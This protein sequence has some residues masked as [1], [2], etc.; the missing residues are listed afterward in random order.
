MSELLNIFS[1]SSINTIRS[2]FEKI[3]VLYVRPRWVWKS[4]LTKNANPLNDF[5]FYLLFYGLI[6]YIFTPNVILVVKLVGLQLI[7]KLQPLL[8]FLIP[9][10]FFNFIWKQKINLQQIFILLFIF[11][12]QIMPFIFIPIAIADFCEIESPYI[13]AHNAFSILDIM[14]IVIV[15]LTLNIS[16][17]KKIIWIFTN[18]LFINIFFLINPL[19]H[20]FYPDLGIMRAKLEMNAPQKEFLSYEYVYKDSDKYLVANYLTVLLKKDSTVINVS[21]QY[22]TV[23]LV[24]KMLEHKVKVK[25]R[26]QFKLDDLIYRGDSSK[27]V[28]KDIKYKK[29]KSVNANLWIKL[30]PDEFIKVKTLDSLRN[31]YND[32]FYPDLKLMDS[33]KGSSKYKGN[34]KLFT[35]FFNYLELFDKI[36]TDDKFLKSVVFR[37]KP[38]EQMSIDD[39]RFLLVY[40]I[41]KTEEGKKLLKAQKQLGKQYDKVLKQFD[42]S[43][44]IHHYLYYPYN[45]YISSQHK[46]KK[47]L[48]YLDV[49]SK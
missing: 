15:P 7:G 5:I 28:L 37:L 22:T 11:W 16:I 13:I 3:L 17:L 46:P 38:V 21:T 24:D 41:H 25:N 32:I 47:E 40:D 39:G 48:K 10:L 33:L 35:M 8:I 26:A 18:Y 9:F 45:M 42:N 1:K 19:I 43:Y 49:K 4:I 36:Y 2:Y 44:I 23:F 12:L 34:K 27:V 31:T 14:M 6:I 29:D 30:D 20:E